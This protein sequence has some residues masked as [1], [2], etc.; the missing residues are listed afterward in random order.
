MIA[1]EDPSEPTLRSL[2]DEADKL[3]AFYRNALR[4]ALWGRGD[5]EEVARIDELFT[6]LD[7]GIGKLSQ[8]QLGFL[9]ESQVGKSSL[10]NAL[11]DRTALPAGGIGPLTAQAV[12]VRHGRDEGFLVSYHGRG[13][14]NRLRFALEGDAERGGMLTR[15]PRSSADAPPPAPEEAEELQIAA[16]D[17]VAD[18]EASDRR[19]PRMEAF[20]AQG[21]RLLSQ[22]DG[23]DVSVL[24]VIGGL[25]EVL[26]MAPRNGA[27][28]RSS[29]APRIAELRERLGTEETVR[30]SDLSSRVEFNKALKL[31]AAGWLSPLVARLELRLAQPVLE[32]IEL[33]DL[34]GIG[35]VGDDAAQVAGDYVRRQADAL[36]IVVRNNGISELLVSALESADVLTRRN[37]DVDGLPL[38]LAVTHLDSVAQSRYDEY[39]AE[40]EEAGEA[41]P[42]LDTVF[43]QL[44]PDMIARVRAQLRTALRASQTYRGARGEEKAK[45]GQVIDAMADHA[46][47]HC[48]AAPDYLRGQSAKLGREAAGVD[49]LRG[50]LGRLGKERHERYRRSLADQIRALRSDLMGALERLRVGLQDEIRSDDERRRIVAAIDIAL[51]PLQARLSAYQGETQQFLRGTMQEILKGLVAGASAKAG[52]RHDELVDYGAGINV[53]SLQAAM[54][55]NGV[56]E[57]RAVDFPGELTRA[58]VNQIAHRWQQDVLGKIREHLK[59]AMLRKVKLVEQ[60]LDD[61]SPVAQDRRGAAAVVV[62]SLEARA[63]TLTLWGQDRLEQFQRAVHAG[64]N[65]VV[66]A[67]FSAACEDAVAR[68]AHRRTGAKDRIL[69]VFR[70][71]GREAIGRATK[72]SLDVLNTQ[73][74]VLLQEVQLQ[75]LQP[76]AN[77]LAQAV[78]LL[79]PAEPPLTDQDRR[80]RA[81]RLAEVERVTGAVPEIPDEASL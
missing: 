18:Q 54:R 55:R 60:L 45:W 74:N 12:R 64:V 44:R 10:I 70:A 46:M 53:R 14:I 1:C 6:S 22:D 38:V 67:E 36:V 72:K 59:Q 19:N 68:E 9:G 17:E 39:A 30:Q 81:E 16:M 5:R 77:P 35:V 78:E 2:P 15:E 29:W 66:Y 25:R 56:W 3:G 28:A 76:S 33:V 75:V 34:P 51:Q 23:G 48:V 71:A 32:H 7:A 40:C 62:S 13:P 11:L 37:F 24:E 65:D 49:A 79:R 43:N 61:T 57:R 47:I 8:L 31:R 63:R 41:P 58:F 73:Y 20:A 52:Q 80:V 42:S 50:E 27:A 69:M 26:G 21:R 4:P